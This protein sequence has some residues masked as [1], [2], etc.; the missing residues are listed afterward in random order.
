M[1]KTF[2]LLFS[3]LVALQINAQREADWTLDLEGSAQDIVF[4][5]ATGTPIVVTTEQYVGIDPKSKAEKWAVKR[6][7]MAALSGVM[8][9]ESDYYE[10][11]LSGLAIIN[12]NIVHVGNGTIILDRE[13]EGVSNVV[14]FHFLPESRQ[15]LA[16]VVSE[17]NNVLYAINM[18]TNSVDWKTVIGKAALGEKMNLSSDSG[19]AYPV[20]KFT[21]VVTNGGQLIFRNGKELA[22]M[23]AKSGKLL[24]SEK[25]KPADY[26]VDDKTN[27]IFVIEKGGG[28]VAAALAGSAAKGN[29]VYAYNLETGKSPWKK[30]LKLDGNVRYLEVWGSD[31]LIVHS[32]GMNFYGIGDGKTKWKNDFKE[33]RI[34]DV[35]ETS[36]GLEVIYRGSRIQ[37]VDAASGKKLWKKHKMLEMD[38]DAGTDVGE[39]MEIDKSNEVDFGTFALY[40]SDGGTF[41]W[42]YYRESGK[43]RNFNSKNITLDPSND[44]LV[45]II[46]KGVVIVNTKDY[47]VKQKK[48]KFGNKNPLTTVKIVPGSGYFVYGK[49]DFAMMDFDGTVKEQRSFKIPGEAGRNLLNTAAALGTAAAT[50]AYISSGTTTA[51]G[52]LGDTFTDDPKYAQMASKGATGMERNA[53][54]ADVLDDVYMERFE[55][56]KENESSAYFFS[57][58]DAGDKVLFEVSKTTGEIEDEMKFLNNQPTYKIDEISGIIYYA[59]KN[60]CYV[61]E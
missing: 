4:H 7:G 27:T 45:A 21:P 34:S 35:A 55:T 43:W 49:N 9:M 58:N 1:K 17:G 46:N 42:I 40:P 31:L 50:T 25:C 20:E 23:D 12:Q 57:K 59:H 13:K 10:I 22:V 8:E 56:F 39:D 3:I 16:E 6:Q 18:K 14:N 19:P 26:A 30:E 61:F 38:S 53:Y 11:P 36:E 60:K 33:K 28:L 37:M 2:I 48:V 47:K 24:W 51:V 15:M 52:V 41:T 5:K 54:I 44:Q 29:V 32:E